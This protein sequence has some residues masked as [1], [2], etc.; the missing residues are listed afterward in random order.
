MS[1]SAEPLP[2]PMQKGALGH[3]ELAVEATH[4]GLHRVHVTLEGQELAGSPVSFSVSSGPPFASNCVLERLFPPDSTPITEKMPISI[5]MKLFDRHGNPVLRP[6]VRIEAKVTVPGAFAESSVRDNE[7][8]THRISFTSGHAG[9]IRLIT[10][11]EGVELPPY[12]LT[13]VKSADSSTDG[14]QHVTPK[15]YEMAP[16]A[17]PPMETRAVAAVSEAM[18][19]GCSAG[20]SMGVAALAAELEC[21]AQTKMED[22]PPTCNDIEQTLGASAEGEHSFLAAATSIGSSIAN[23]IWAR[24]S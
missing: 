10:R 6:G 15:E 7:D 8:G 13:A 11:V 23:M 3:Y 17:A 22:D 24:T 16:T 1:A 21:K 9:E 18:P 5:D 14:A 19:L 20:L 2:L 4:A 12:V